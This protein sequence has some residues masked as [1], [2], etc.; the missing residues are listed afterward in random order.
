MVGFSDSF[1]ISSGFA[2]EVGEPILL[3][4][5]DTDDLTLRI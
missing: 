5:T 4:K 2:T 1:E 3:D